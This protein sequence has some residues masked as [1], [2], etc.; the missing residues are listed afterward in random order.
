VLLLNNA[1]SI[2]G[3]KFAD[4]NFTLKHTGAGNYTLQI[5]PPHSV[6]SVEGN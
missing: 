4:E 6:V 5:I 1:Q 2:Y 3:E